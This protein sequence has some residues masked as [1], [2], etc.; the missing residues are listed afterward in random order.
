[1][2]GNR[3]S[4]HSGRAG[5]ARCVD[6][7][8][9]CW[10]SITKGAVHTH[11]FPPRGPKCAF[12]ELVSK[13]TLNCSLGPRGKAPQEGACRSLGV[14]FLLC[15]SQLSLSVRSDASQWT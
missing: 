9:G 15:C 8:P 7:L 5:R 12:T 10:S 1:M 11:H 4:P 3:W 13:T 6:S 2:K 14:S